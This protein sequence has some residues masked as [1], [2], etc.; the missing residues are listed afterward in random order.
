VENWRLK[1]RFWGVRGSVPTPVQRNMGFGGNT[2]SLEL[3]LPS[4]ESI[5]FDAG[6]GICELGPT[7]MTQ[8]LIHLFFTHLHWDHLQGLPFFTPLYNPAASLRLYSSSYSSDLKDGLQSQMSR[9]YFP[10]DFEN[11]LSKREFVDMETSPIQVGGVK[12]RPF[13]LWHPNGACGYRIEAGGAVIVYATDREHGHP[14]LDAL[15]EEWAQGADLLIHD[16]QYTPQE[17]EGRKNWGHSTWQEAVRVSQACGVKQLALFHH[18]PRHDDEAVARI[19]AEARRQFPQAFAAK[20]GL[21][22]TL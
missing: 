16:A 1:L 2:A 7:L 19:E 4:G 10:V 3:Q 6:T 9:P 21:T 12:I 15:F 20:E 13:P 17:F 18:D 5:V 22:I 11:A 8:S 14:E